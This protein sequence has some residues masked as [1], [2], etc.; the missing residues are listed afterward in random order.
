MTVDSLE[1]Q[2]F[3]NGFIDTSLP[4]LISEVLTKWMCSIPVPSTKLEDVFIRDAVYLTF[5][6]TETLEHLYQIPE[7]QILHIHGRISEGDK[8]IVGHN[9]H[10]NPADYWD[11]NNDMREN[12]ECMQRLTDMNTLR[13][14]VYELIERN[15]KFFEGLG[16]I[17]DIFIKG[18]SCDEV[19]YPYFV[20]VNES[21]ACSAKWHFNPYKVDDIHRIETL[22]YKIGISNYIF[23]SCPT[24]NS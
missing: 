22:I 11:D 3:N 10:I 6:Y 8:L 15:E 4:D 1:N 12:N 21:V 5:N 20:K 2:L 7:Q 13:K 9:R 17:E 19:D 24:E 14:P 23:D 16:S 18:H